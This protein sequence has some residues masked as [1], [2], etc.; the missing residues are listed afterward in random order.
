MMMNNLKVFIVDD[1]LIVRSRLVMMLAGVE[2]VEIIGQVGDAH[3]AG[4]VIAS[5]KP[6]VVI[7]DF[8]L[9]SGT[10]LDVL[11]Y[12][13]G[14]GSPPKIIMLTNYATEQLRVKC[15]F[16][17]VDYF[18]DKSTEFEKVLDAITS[19]KAKKQLN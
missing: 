7:L 10:G 19:L 15:T 14:S 9:Q 11:R 16:H 13:E 3:T 18:F 8:Q 4:S 1:S 12:V 6:D 2:G 17:G 5:S